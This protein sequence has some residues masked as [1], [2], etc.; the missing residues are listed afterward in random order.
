M[1]KGLRKRSMFYEMMAK[2]Y[3]IT[4]IWIL[5]NFSFSLGTADDIRETNFCITENNCL[6]AFE[7]EEKHDFFLIA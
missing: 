1:K 4:S 3:Q 5:L 2:Y 6:L 7:E